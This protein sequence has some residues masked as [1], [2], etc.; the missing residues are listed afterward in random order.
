MGLDPFSLE[1]RTG[2]CRALGSVHIEE[3]GGGEGWGGQT[4]RKAPE[5]I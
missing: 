1:Y 4:T 2:A 5:E 3:A